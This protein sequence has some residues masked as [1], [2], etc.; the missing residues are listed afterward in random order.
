MSTETGTSTLPTTRRTTSTIRS[1]GM[2]S[3]PSE[4]PRAL[5]TPALLVPTAAPPASTQATA[6]AASQTVGMTRGDG[7]L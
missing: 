5:A 4:K 7:P 1:K 2:L 3:S 6:E